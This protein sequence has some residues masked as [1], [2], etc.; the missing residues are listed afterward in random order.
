MSAS[1]ASLTPRDGCDPG[2]DGGDGARAAEHVGGDDCLHGLGPVRD[3]HQHLRKQQSVDQISG[4]RAPI[5]ARDAGGRGRR[6]ELAGEGER[7]SLPSWGAGTMPWR[8]AGA[9]VR[10]WSRRGEGGAEA[11]VMMSEVLESGRKAS[12]RVAISL[13]ALPEARTRVG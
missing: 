11:E 2:L 10:A 6:E 4:S 7:G 8:P 13:L 1:A 9:R 3:R 12:G 5:R